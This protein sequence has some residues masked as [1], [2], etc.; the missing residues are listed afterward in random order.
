MTLVGL[1]A[2]N[3]GGA[4]IANAASAFINRR[5]E[6]IATLKCLGATAAHHH[7][8][9][10]DRDSAVA[11]L[12]IIIGLTA[13]SLAPWIAKAAIGDLIPLPLTAGVEI[14]PWRLLPSSASSSH[15]LHHVAPR[16]TRHV[17]ASAL[18]RHHTQAFGGWPGIGALITIA[19]AL[20]HGASRLCEL[21]RCAHHHHLSG[22]PCGSF[23]VA[24][25][26]GGGDRPSHP[27]TAEAQKAPS[28]AMLSPMCI[29]RARRRSRSSWRWA[30]G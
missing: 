17:P 24:P 4:G 23:V 28:G 9:L 30:S 12:A 14:S 5:T 10:S 21:R 19:L 29:A 27:P 2:L 3:H 16:R 25:R 18:F 20:A 6:A 8:H 15:C 26:T 7:R 13:G 1:T 11:A 22:R